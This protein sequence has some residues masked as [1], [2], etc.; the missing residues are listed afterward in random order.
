MQQIVINLADE[1]IVKK[2][3]EECKK[4]ECEEQN[5]IF[6]GFLSNHQDY[7]YLFEDKALIEQEA[8]NFI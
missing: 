5:L 4:S 2:T 7:F 3:I 1:E 6:L 8:N